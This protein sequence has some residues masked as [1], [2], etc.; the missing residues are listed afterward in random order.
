MSGKPAAGFFVEHLYV[1]DV[2]MSRYWTTA[3]EREGKNPM[4][5]VL[6]Y[7]FLL[8]VLAPFAILAVAYT[9][10]WIKLPN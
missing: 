10:G 6:P 9:Q 4:Q 7:I 5:T 2:D 8:T 1:W 3:A